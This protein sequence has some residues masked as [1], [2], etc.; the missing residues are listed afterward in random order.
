MDTTC[1]HSSENVCF[2]PLSWL[3]SIY[4][5]VELCITVCFSLWDSISLWKLRYH[6]ILEYFVKLQT[7]CFF[8]F[9][10]NLHGCYV[11]LMV[12]FIPIYH[13]NRRTLHLNRFQLFC[14]RT[15]SRK[16]SLLSW[17]FMV[18]PCMF[19]LNRFS[20]CQCFVLF[21]LLQ[22]VTMVSRMHSEL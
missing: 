17:R 2:K 7:C 20:K 8:M 13:D 21:V 4:Q 3:G 5:M 15:V 18:V 22:L 19:L 14:K 1:F 6:L 11:T 12:N 16:I 9:I 10:G